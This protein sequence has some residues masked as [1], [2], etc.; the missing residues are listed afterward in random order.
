[1]PKIRHCSAAR[2]PQRRHLTSET[3]SQSH[4]GFRH[5]RLGGYQFSILWVDI[6]NPS[7]IKCSGA[8][9]EM[10]PIMIPSHPRS[11]LPAPIIDMP[12]FFKEC[13]ESPWWWRRTESGS[14]CLL[15]FVGVDVQRMTSVHVVLK[16]VVGHPR[17]PAQRELRDV[18]FKLIPPSEMITSLYLRRSGYC[19]TLLCYPSA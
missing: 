18:D 2:L 6:S 3:S 9:Q 15:K 12:K 7:K 10:H 17:A 11:L 1:M 13:E 16:H 4:D 8:T 5:L 14:I 19:G